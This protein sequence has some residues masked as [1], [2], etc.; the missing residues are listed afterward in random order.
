MKT[1][2][3]AVM[4]QKGGC[5][6]TTVCVHLAVGYERAGKS[7]Q[8][9]DADRQ[10]SAARWALKAPQFK[11]KAPPVSSVRLEGLTQAIEASRGEFEYTIIDTAGDFKAD[12]QKQ[13]MELLPLVDVV[14]VPILPTPLD[15]DGAHDLL[16][17]LQAYTRANDT[18][19]RVLLLVNKAKRNA[20]TASA[21]KMLG[22]Y[23]FQVL[24]TNMQD[25]V[26]YAAEVGFGGSAFDR[27]PSDKARI[28]ITE[29]LNEVETHA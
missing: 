11:R 28:E 15:V 5:G 21:K 23:G 22:G 20:L 10:G 17:A 6:K 24:G 26:A 7:V 29:L 27:R 12:A 2:T 8:L 9:L 25:R 19:P 18:G 3:I 13:V 4:N 14:I 16:Q 1:R